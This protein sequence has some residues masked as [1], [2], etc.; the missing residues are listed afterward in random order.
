MKKNTFL[1]FGF[2]LTII[3]LVLMFLEISAQGPLQTPEEK[4]V[5]DAEIENGFEMGKIP[6]GET[7]DYTE[8]YIQEIIRNLNIMI[9]NT[10]K[11]AN[12][13]YN[14]ATEDDLYD[15][16]ES[17][18]ITCQNCETAPCVCEYDDEGECT[19]CSCECMDC[20]CKA[21]SS[22]CRCGCVNVACSEP[23][24]GKSTSCGCQGKCFCNRDSCSIGSCTCLVNC[25]GCNEN[26][27]DFCKCDYKCNCSGF[28]NPL[29]ELFGKVTDGVAIIKRAYKKI[30]IANN[31]ITNLVDAE[32]KITLCNCPQ[33]VGLSFIKGE[34]EIPEELNRWKIV[35]AFTNSRILK[36]KMTRMTLLNCMTA[37]DEIETEGGIVI[38]PGFEYFAVTNTMEYLCFQDLAPVGS[39]YCYPYN[40]KAFLTDDEK[41][42]CR[43]NK[44]SEKCE[45]IIKDLM[46]NFFCCEG[47]IK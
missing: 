4:C 40:S 26:S 44:D 17:Y 35:N 39:D 43:K 30:V 37:L 25:S 31:N 19:H 38:L 46:H 1:K 15:L 8:L 12:T 33:K 36:P 20:K 9:T 7:V 3:G 10:E 29:C 24:K 41:E 6:I 21:D 22:G 23:N 45:E 13:A 27:A 11:A 28:K 2:T 18:N 32:G 34:I 47:V 42:T 16:F 5:I 14:E